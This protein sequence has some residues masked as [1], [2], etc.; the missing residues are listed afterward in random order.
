MR[1]SSG[2]G[3]CVSDTGEIDFQ[4]DIRAVKGG[5][6]ANTKDFANAN[7]E[8]YWRARLWLMEGDSI[9]DDHELAA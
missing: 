1:F 6:K 9:P 5:A 3:P 7:A 2:V 4:I 8:I